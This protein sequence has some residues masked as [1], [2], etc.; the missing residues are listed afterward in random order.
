MIG[1]ACDNVWSLAANDTDTGSVN[2]FTYS[3]VANLQ[4]NAGNDT[5][6]FGQNSAVS[7]SIDGGAGGNNVMN[8][9]AYGAPVSVMLTGNDSGSATP[10]ANDGPNGFANINFVISNDAQNNSLMGPNSANLWLITGNDSGT[11]NGFGFSGMANLVGNYNVDDFV[12]SSQ[13]NISGSIDGGSGE[14]LVPDGN[15]GFSDQGQFVDTLDYSAWG[16]HSVTVDLR[17]DTDIEQVI[18]ANGTG[19]NNVLQGPN[20]DA[21]WQV[22]G[23]N[24]GSLYYDDASQVTTFSSFKSLVGGSG[25]DAFQIVGGS[26]QGSIAGGAGVNTLDYSLFT[27]GHI[28][29]SLTGANAGSVGNGGLTRGF[30][31]IQN[32][33]GT[34]ATGTSGDS[35]TGANSTT[36][37][38]L[39]GADS[40]NVNGTIAYSGIANLVGGFASYSFVFGPGHSVSGTIDAGST[41]L[42]ATN[43]LNYASY[44]SAVDVNL[45]S[46][47][48]TGIAGGFTNIN[49][50]VGANGVGIPTTLTGSD[51]GSTYNF[52]GAG[53]GNISIIITLFTFSNVTTVDGGAGDDTFAFGANG[54]IAGNIFGGGGNDTLNYG[55]FGQAVV[56][57]LDD[58]TVTLA[59][60]GAIPAGITGI[61]GGIE[62]FNG[63][64][65]A[66]ATVIGANGSNAWSITGADAGNVDGFAFSNT[67]SLTGGASAAGSDAFAI[68]AAGSLS[69]TITAGPGSSETVSDV[70][71]GANFS[72]SDGSIVYGG[73]HNTALAGTFTGAAITATG[74]TTHN[75]NVSGWTARMVLPTSSAEPARTTSF[76]TT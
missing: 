65:S 64:N 73:T 43:T 47:S 14:N 36:T 54:S 2:G 15:G 70:N 56:L 55:S 18:G 46:D 9:T 11:V 42:G 17:K 61:Y 19:A 26:L 22:T 51:T 74:S 75:F 10:I 21:D 30:S 53:S 31:A 23:T 28:S 20:L 29:V 7:G 25:N 35:L 4:G 33:I 34:G 24:S 72:L 59:S 37:V 12:F 68:G 48:A 16:N 8:F 58:D 38:N 1:Y 27:A 69:G 71:S 6:N 60:N 57:N 13:K 41:L 45:K 3:G 49:A 66:H 62:S 5:F 32:L 40:G 50:L 52:T 44:G 67:K 76:T 63:A 39:T